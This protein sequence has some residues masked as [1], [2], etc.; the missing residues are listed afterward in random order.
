MLINRRISR[1]FHALAGD[2]EL[3]KEKYYSRWVKPR[4]RRIP[5]LRFSNQNGFS[6]R[7]AHSSNLGKWLEHGHLIR[8]TETDW[9]R[10]YKLKHNWSQGSARVKEF[11][12]KQNPPAL[13]LVKLCKG[14]IFA[15]DREH[16]LRAW[17]P[18]S[19]KL[20]IS[21][22]LSLP[23][24]SWSPPSALGVTSSS[25]LEVVDIGIG[26][27]NGAFRIYSWAIHSASLNLRYA[28]PPSSF[29]AIT[30]ISPVLPYLSTLARNRS[31]SVYHFADF[32][33]EAAPPRRLDHPQLLASLSAPRQDG[34][35]TLTIRVSPTNVIAGIAFLTSRLNQ[36]W[37]VGLQEVCLKRAAPNSDP[38]RQGPEEENEVD[39]KSEQQADAETSKE[40]CRL[41]YSDSLSFSS[42]QGLAPSLIN[43]SHPY[44]L[45]SYPD[46]TMEIHLVKSNPQSLSIGPGRRLWGHTSTISGAEVSDRGLAVS[47]SRKGNEVRIWDLEGIATSGSESRPRKSS[48]SINDT[49]NELSLAKGWVGFDDEQVLVLREWERGVQA[50]RCYD[51][52]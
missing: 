51:F 39:G 37:C 43:Y 34:P 4:V 29:G 13:V 20:L 35:V 52:T 19:Y 5:V 11:T 23:S 42:S 30:E 2:S 8:N 41:T 33:S 24:T 28:R 36:S 50:L 14:M 48:V 45:I 16:G 44:L 25:C 38:T 47:V 49:H 18:R 6:S 26:F 9:K 27:E 17:E 7:F 22:P 3:W 1:R 15:A 32:D 40:S 12:V 31:M 21:E 10:Q 46:N